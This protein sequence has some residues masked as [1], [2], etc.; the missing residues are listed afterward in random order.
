MWGC[1]NRL[2]GLSLTH[3][4]INFL[5]TIRGSLK[6]GYYLQTRNTMVR[7][8]SCLPDS[9]RNLA[10]EYVRVSGNWLNSELTCLTSLHEIGWYFL[11][12]DSLTYPNCASFPF[13]YLFIFN[14][15]ICTLIS[16]SIVYTH[17]SLSLFLVISL[18]CSP[19]PTAV[20]KKFRLDINVVRV[21][22]LNFVPRSEIFVHYNGQLRASHLIL[23]CV[24]SYT[25][26]QDL[27]SALTV[28][29]PLLSYLDVHLPGFL[30][31]GL[32]SGEERHLGP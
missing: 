8:I 9:N 4:D 16:L 32:T 19:S 14:L 12:P 23:G 2:Y 25:S 10:E 7:L 21:Q 31:Q 13:I 1:L 17:L 28:G 30:L 20:S 5:Y 15:F 18:T 3:H 29:S 11:F 26:Y 6:L 22:E 27:S 24:P